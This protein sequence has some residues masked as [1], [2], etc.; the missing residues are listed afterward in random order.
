MLPPAS[1]LTLQQRPALVA[2]VFACEI[3]SQQVARLY[4]IP[5]RPSAIRDWRH[6]RA[7][8]G[9]QVALRRGCRSKIHT[10]LRQ[11]QQ[12]DARP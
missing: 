3:S 5:E 4:Y 11:Q 2:A 6:S 7:C 12:Y 1:P 8:A 10:S 9:A